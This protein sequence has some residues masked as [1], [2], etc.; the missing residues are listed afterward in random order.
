MTMNSDKFALPA[1]ACPY[2]GTLGLTTSSNRST[3]SS[4]NTRQFPQLVRHDG[5]DWHIHAIKPDRPLHDRIVA[6][7]AMGVLDLL[8]IGEHGRL[9]R[10]EA[11]G[12]DAALVDLSRNRSRRF[13]NVGNCANRSHVATYRAR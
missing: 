10:C 9:R 7:A 4:T 5:H 12:C 1:T 6:E 2:S 11:E 3:P 13:C 8:R